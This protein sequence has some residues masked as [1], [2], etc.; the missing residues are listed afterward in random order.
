MVG[1]PAYLGVEHVT[2]D[3]GKVVANIISISRLPKGMTAPDKSGYVRS[4][5]W[6]QKRKAY[7]DEVKAWAD[8]QQ[9]VR[10]PAGADYPDQSPEDDSTEDLPF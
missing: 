3:G 9:K 8:A 7:A 2:L 5:Y 10:T 1:F 6:E 4:D